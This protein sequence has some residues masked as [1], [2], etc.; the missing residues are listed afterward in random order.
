MNELEKMKHVV[1]KMSNLYAE[2]WELEKRPLLENYLQ[3][4]SK[5]VSVPVLSVCGRGTAEVRYTKYLAYYLDHRSLHGVGDAFLKA[6]LKSLQINTAAYDI[7]SCRVMPEKYLGTFKGRGQH[8]VACYCDIA[9]ISDQLCL[10]IE[11]KLMSGESN[12]LNSEVSQLN[13]YASTIGQ[14]PDFHDKDIYKVYLTPDG[15]LPHKSKGWISLTHEQIVEAGMDMLREQPLSIQAKYNFRSFL[16]DLII[17]PYERSED[18]IRIMSD[19]AYDL[20]HGEI[21]F[22]KARRLDR[23]M[24]RNEL[25]VRLIMEVSI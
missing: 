11:Q 23:I 12:H 22:R 14:N 1:Q 13:R 24:K 25:L 2:K 9:V 7:T 4:I 3:E 18:E 8:S 15:T 19:L 21:N 17:G 16:M 10:F 6:I 5:G 20:V